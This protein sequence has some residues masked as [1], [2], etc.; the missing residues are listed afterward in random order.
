MDLKG[1]TK[2]SEAL[3]AEGISAFLNEYLTVMNEVIF[4]HGGTIDKFIGDAIMVLFGAPQDMSPEEQ[5]KRATYCAKVMQERMCD[6]AHQWRNDG[7]G[8]LQM[9]IGIHHG[10][11][12]VG[13]FGSTQRSDYT[14]IGPCVNFAARI[15][16][17]S[18]PG[19]VFV[20]EATAKLM[21][22]GTTAEVGAFELKG[23]EG[24][25]TLYRVV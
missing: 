8:H 15:E 1:F 11:A 4:E 9:R 19:E 25:A 22:E 14:A 13:N 3:G 2:T 7:A 20:S 10:K 18:E 24:K 5:V 16:S 23:I 12:V 17:A 21:G 6:L